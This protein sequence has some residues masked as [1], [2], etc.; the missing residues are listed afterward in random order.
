MEEFERLELELKNI[1][2][3]YIIRVR[4][5]DALKSQLASRDMTFNNRSDSPIAKVIDGSMTILPE[6]L[7]DSD[8]ED[9]S[10]V[11]GDNGVQELKDHHL[12][13]NGIPP[14]GSQKPA[15]REELLHR[16]RSSRLRTGVA[17]R[18]SESRLIGT[19][20]GELDNL[21]SSLGSDD[22]ESELDLNGDGLGNLHSEDD[23]D[24][25]SIGGGKMTARTQVPPANNSSSN[26]NNGNRNSKAELSDEDF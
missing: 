9:E 18:G 16:A 7:I 19:M 15:S 26:N 6:G 24:E 3:Q 1:F 21:D 10:E 4:C 5:V 12:L 20:N 25:T 13:E 11:V 8:D 23:F 17:I 2:E 14:G 22:T